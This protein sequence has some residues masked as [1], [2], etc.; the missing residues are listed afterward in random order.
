MAHRPNGVLRRAFTLIEI[1]IVVVIL[2]ILAAIV[3]PQYQDA[4]VTA[5][6]SALRGQ[7]RTLRGQISVYRA[8]QGADPNLVAS[9]WSPLV[10]ADYLGIA[11][12]N[13]LNGS[14]TVAAAAG[15]GVGW[16]WRTKTGPS[17][18]MTLYATDASGLVEYP[19]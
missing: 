17:S 3:V 13:P 9:Q 8:N 16:V 7:L 6:D 1:L 12:S 18:V 14:S 4:A 11:P 2:G 19:E 10:D 5:G 15:A